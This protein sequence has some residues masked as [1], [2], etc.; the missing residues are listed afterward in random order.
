MDPLL[1]IKNSSKFWVCVHVRVW[2]SP[3]QKF[4]SNL[5]EYLNIV[6]Y[7]AVYFNAGISQ[8]IKYKGKLSNCQLSKSKMATPYYHSQ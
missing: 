6:Q 4:F 2:L 8:Y 7:I 3:I 5:C 1:K